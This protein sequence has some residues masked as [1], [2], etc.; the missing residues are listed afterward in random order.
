MLTRKKVQ[1]TILLVAG[2]I[3]L[4]NLIASRFFFRLDYT[5]DQ[6]YTL[7]KATKDILSRLGEPVT[8]SAYFSGNLPPN[9]E[10]VRQD[11]RDMLVEYASSSGGLIVYEFI[12]PGESQET[13]MQAQQNGIQPIMINVRERDQMKQQRA[14]LGALIRMADRREVIPFI[15]P[16]AAMEYALSTNIKKLSVKDKPKIA[17]LQGHGEAPLSSIPQLYNQLSV[18][19]SVETFEFSDTA[20]VPSEYKTLVVIAPTDTVPPVHFKYLDE[21][22]NKGGRLLLALNFVDGDLNTGMGSK[23]YTGFQGWLKQKGIEAE[24]NFVIDASCS[25]V[26]VQQRQGFFVMNT[27]VRFPFIPV[28]T[29]F[30]AHPVTEG[31]EQVVLPFASPLRLISTD[32]L[33]VMFPLAVTSDKSGIQNVPVYFDVMKQWSAADFPLS[34]LPVAVITEGRV[35][36][37]SG[38]KMV[39]FSDGGFAVNGEGQSAQQLSEDN[40]SFMANAVDWLSDDT[41]LIELRTKGVTSRPLSASLDDGTKTLLKYLNFLF[42][43]VLII[44][45]GV[46]RFQVKRKVRNELMNTEYVPENKQ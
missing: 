6:R 15:Q 35:P 38:Y 42:P 20:G 45:Y 40:V 41:G 7:S 26:M 21:F 23:V 37:T 3:I 43:M 8:I 5:A 46:F 29:N 16:S 32:T 12:N 10:K 2:I 44:L 36:G 28:I 9:I 25:N 17:L 31:I 14:Y 19:Y 30:T 4:L 18:L 11:F 39:V 1:T 13:E 27:P 22:L 33:V 34:S 24:E